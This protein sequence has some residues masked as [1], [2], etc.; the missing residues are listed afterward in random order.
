MS[1]NKIQK[2]M[3]YDNNIKN[4]IFVFVIS[5]LFSTTFY[6][7]IAFIR[8]LCYYYLNIKMDYYVHLALFQ[9]ISWIEMIKK[10][11]PITF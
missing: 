10:N 11:N 4:T 3:R 8:T 1:Q 2:Y 9:K 7:S 6:K 5:H